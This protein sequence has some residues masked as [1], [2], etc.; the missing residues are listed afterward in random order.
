MAVSIH[1]SILIHAMCIQQCIFI[2][3]VCIQQFKLIENIYIH[4]PPKCK[5]TH[6]QQHIYICVHMFT[7]IF[8]HIYICTHVHIYIS[9]CTYVYNTEH[10]WTKHINILPN[11]SPAH[12]MM[13]LRHSSRHQHMYVVY[14]Y[15]Q[16]YI[17]ICIY[18]HLCKYTYRIFKLRRNVLQCTATHFERFALILCD[19]NAL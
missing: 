3:V 11:T 13:S 19:C 7:Y 15:I 2:H 14:V 1:I 4:F 16:C 18:M 5:P 6:H 10:S 8:I 9:I 17:Y 12:E